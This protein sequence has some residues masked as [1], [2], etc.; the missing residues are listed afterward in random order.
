MENEIKININNPKQLEKL[1]REHKSIFT[2]AFNNVFQEITN[3]PAA[4]AWNE[5]LNYKDESV[6]WGN[7]NEIIFIVIAACALPFVFLGTSSLGTTFQNSFGSVNGEDI[8]QADLQVATN[9]TVQKFK[10]V[11]GDDFDFN[12][13]DESIQLETVKQELI[14]QKVLLSESMKL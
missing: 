13:L 11:Y 3:E 6:F 2:S 1:Y 10:N 8:T 4:Q 14:S 9:M 7:K 12:E 5:R